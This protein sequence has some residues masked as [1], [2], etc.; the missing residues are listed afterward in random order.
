L[1]I[2]IHIVVDLK[3]AINICILFTIVFFCNSDALCMTRHENGWAFKHVILAEWG[4]GTDV[5]NEAD[6][7]EDMR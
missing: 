6:R 5:R 4:V 2:N 1:A 3:A 7:E